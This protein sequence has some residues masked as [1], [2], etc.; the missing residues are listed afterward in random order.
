MLSAT[1]VGDVF[2]S[3]SA[4]AILAGIQAVT[5]EAGCLLIIMNYTGKVHDDPW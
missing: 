4:E 5:G 2:A 1:V 3:P